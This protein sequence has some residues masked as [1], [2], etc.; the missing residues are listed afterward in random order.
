[1]SR[2]YLKQLG[3]ICIVEYYDV[4]KREGKEEEERDRYMLRGQS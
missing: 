1:M 2:G 3:Y 4:V